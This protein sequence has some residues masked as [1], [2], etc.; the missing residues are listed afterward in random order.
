[1]KI[2]LNALFRVLP[3]VIGQGD[4]F[5]PLSQ[6]ATLIIPAQVQTTKQ[7]PQEGIQI[8][9]Q[10]EIVVANNITPRVLEEFLRSRVEADLTNR[11]F[12]IR[13]SAILANQAQMLVFERED[14]E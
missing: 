1:M 11:G 4:T 5:V 13:D 9:V 3:L 8:Q 7:V 14:N 6:K 10:A 12:S 2:L